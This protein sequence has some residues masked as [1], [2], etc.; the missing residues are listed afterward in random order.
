MLIHPPPQLVNHLPIFV[1][2]VP[3]DGIAVLVSVKVPSDVMRVEVEA[4]NIERRWQL[5]P[6]IQFLLVKDLGFVFFLH[7]VSCLLVDQ[8]T[9][10]I[11]SVPLE[12]HQ[13]P[14]LVWQDHQVTL[15][16]SLQVSQDIVHIELSE[17]WIPHVPQPV[18]IVLIRVVCSHLFY[19]LLMLLHF[20]LLFLFI[21]EDLLFHLLQLFLV[22]LFRHGRRPLAISSSCLLLFKVEHLIIIFHKLFFLSLLSLLLSLFL[23]PLELLLLFLLFLQLELLLFLSLLFFFSLF[24]LLSHLLGLLLL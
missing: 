19:R 1:L 17:L 16:I 20:L 9:L 22:F 3:N 12:I 4:L 23:L 15:L 11:D 14:L 6:L 8:V 5:S 21:F 18:V 2:V 24:L 10:L 13:L 7:H